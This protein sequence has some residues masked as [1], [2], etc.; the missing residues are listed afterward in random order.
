MLKFPALTQK[1]FPH[2]TYGT[3][4]DSE[5]Y[6]KSFPVT[7]KRYFFQIL[8]SFVKTDKGLKRIRKIAPPTFICPGGKN[9]CKVHEFGCP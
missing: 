6:K 5:T 9:Y 2:T 8:K 4:V 7:L 3:K 1:R